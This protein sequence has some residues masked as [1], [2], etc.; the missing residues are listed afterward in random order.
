MATL[1]ALLGAMFVALPSASAQTATYTCKANPEQ[2]DALEVHNGTNFVALSDPTNDQPTLTAEATTTDGDNCPVV[3]TDGTQFPTGLQQASADGDKVNLVK[4]DHDGDA[5]G[6][7]PSP[8]QWHWDL[9]YKVNQGAAKSDETNVLLLD[10][11]ANPKSGTDDG[12]ARP[13]SWTIP[14]VVDGAGTA[15]TFSADLGDKVENSD[16]TGSVVVLAKN[17]G[18]DGWKVTAGRVGEA[19][20]TITD[21]RSADLPSVVTNYTFEVKD[22]SAAVADSEAAAAAVVRSVTLEIDDTDDTVG[23]AVTGSYPFTITTTNIPVLPDSAADDVPYIRVYVSGEL[24]DAFVR[25]RDQGRDDDGELISIDKTLDDGKATYTGEISVPKGTTPGEYTLDVTIYTDG[26]NS[27]VYGR[28][29][30]GYKAYSGSDVLIVGD[31]GSNVSEAVLVLS[32]LN[33]DGD[34]VAEG[35]SQKTQLASSAAK[36]DPIRLTLTSLNAL[37][38]PSNTTPQQ[39]SVTLTAAGATIK[40]SHSVDA[41]GA[42]VAADG[43]TGDNSLQFY[44]NAASVVV[45]ITKDTPGEVEVSALVVDP[46]GSGYD[47]SDTVS[48]TFTGP[49]KTVSLSDATTTLLN[50]YVDHKDDTADDTDTDPRDNISLKLTAS[51]ADGHAVVPTGNATVT[52]ADPDGTM[53]ATDG[54][55]QKIV[56]SQK[57]TATTNTISLRVAASVTAPNPL[58]SGEYTVTAKDGAR[59]DTATFTVAG[60]ADTVSMEASEADEDGQLEVTV[61]VTDAEGNHVADGTAVEIMAADLRGDSDPVILR[62]STTGKTKAG[63]AKATFIEVGYG[64]AAIIATA[65]GKTDVVRVNSTFDAPVPEAMP[66]EEASVACLSNLSGFTTWSCGV[67][68]SASEIFELVSGRGATALHLWNGSAWVRYSVVDGAMVPGSSDFMVTQYDNLYISN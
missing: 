24:E 3:G 8:E 34:P 16:T 45:E 17:T 9:D 29:W 35:T 63:V 7:S 38:N 14:Q 56:V 51:D 20:I 21:G 40:H 36:G 41:K 52:I 50:R 67:E 5:D 11:P 48:L 42:Y 68:S 26:T 18:T 49:A 22:V 12:D 10:N 54:A 57:V 64:P 32:P 30:T 59:K 25:T 31:A 4:G 6:D 65:D 19:T 44:S 53:V 46:V 1:V 43:R 28:D 60:L 33:A 39:I 58:K 27:R 37:G 2:S 23:N 55:G 47:G 13:Q 15:R 61:T 66:E 62:T